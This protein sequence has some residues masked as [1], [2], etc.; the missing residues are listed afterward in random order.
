M[1]FV[2]CVESVDDEDDVLLA[3]AENT[4]DLIDCVGGIE[5]H[6]ALLPTV[7]LLAM[8]EDSTVRDAVSPWSRIYYYVM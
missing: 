4:G 2:D 1:W 6:Y 3:I 8:V 7:E 5:F